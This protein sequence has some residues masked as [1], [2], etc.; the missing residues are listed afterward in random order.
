[1]SSASR[2]CL[3]CDKDVKKYL[4]D[5]EN[6]SILRNLLKVLL[7]IFE[8]QRKSPKVDEIYIGMP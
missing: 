5:G 1:M 6:E 4:V 3:L 2:V 8:F 7:V